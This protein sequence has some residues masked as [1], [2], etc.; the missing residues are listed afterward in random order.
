MKHGSNPQQAAVTEA[1]KVSPSALLTWYGGEPREV[2]LYEA[3]S[4]ENPM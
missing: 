1:G 2:F 3:I 4:H